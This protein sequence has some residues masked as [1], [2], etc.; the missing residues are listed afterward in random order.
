MASRVNRRVVK[1]RVGSE[2]S[3]TLGSNDPFSDPRK[4]NDR[5]K[6]DNLDLIPL[7]GCR[8]VSDRRSSN[9]TTNDPWWIMRNYLTGSH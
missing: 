3:Y 9:Y 7:G 1:K 6:I 5:R 8:R 2:T 4:Q